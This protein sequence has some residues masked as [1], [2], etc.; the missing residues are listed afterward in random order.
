MIEIIQKLPEQKDIYHIPVSQNS[1]Y[2]DREVKKK[3]WGGMMAFLKQNK[4]S[5]GI[6]K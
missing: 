4:V 5:N 1:Q 3:G 2:V 6:K